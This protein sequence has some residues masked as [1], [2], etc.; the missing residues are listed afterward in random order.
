M[1]TFRHPGSRSAIALVTALAALGLALGASLAA[2]A[3]ERPAARGQSEACPEADRPA[4]RSTP[5][6]LRRSVRCLVNL[7]RAVRGRSKLA[8]DRSLQKAS[9]KHAAVMV[10]AQCLAHSCGDEPELPDRV[11]RSGYL[12][13]ADTWQVAESTG[14]GVTARAMVKNWMA[15]TYHRINIL[16]K[17][18]ADIGVGVVQEPIERRCDKDFATFAV[19][20]GWRAPDA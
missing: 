10:E 20:F 3:G 14:C 15:D 19:I 12:E 8:N 16:E 13:G 1:T 18:Y 5:A 4:E 7:Q 11:E 9:Q 6:Q 2:G 17:S